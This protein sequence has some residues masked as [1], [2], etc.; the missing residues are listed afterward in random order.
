[1]IRLTLTTDQE[2]AAQAAR[3]DPALLPLERDRVEMVLLSAR[4]WSPPAI[5]EHLKYHPT[6]VR[7]ALKAFQARG[8]V[9]LWHQ[10]PGPPPD[11]VRRTQVTTALDQ[12][13]AQPRTWTAAQLAHALQ[14]A[15]ISLSP[16]QT[17]RYLRE[18]GARWRRTA[19]SLKH[20]Q[21]SSKIERAKGVLAMLGK[22]PPRG[23]SSAST[24]TSAALAPRSR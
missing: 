18:M 17:R 22:G 10:R 14:E 15:G 16:R 24:S 12:L 19:R 23:S 7:T 9:G 13:L 6:T 20:K 5:A 8:L 21:D 11:S 2:A 1:M 3:R 4:G